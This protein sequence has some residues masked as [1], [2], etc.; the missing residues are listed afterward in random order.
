VR[1]R[2]YSVVV[3][4]SARSYSVVVGVRA[5]SQPLGGC[6]RRKSEIVLGSCGCE[7]ENHTQWSCEIALGG[8]ECEREVTLRVVVCVSARLHSVIV[9]V[10]VRTHSA[11]G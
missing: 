5:R 11:I 10:S 4:V 3:G 2:S 7:R 8:C 9:G 6:G 1:A